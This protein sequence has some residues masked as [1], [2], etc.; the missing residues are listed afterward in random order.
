[1]FIEKIERYKG[2]TFCITLSNGRRSAPLYLNKSVVVRH[3]LAEDMELSPDDVR[4][5]RF[6]NECRRARERALYLL[7]ERDYSARS[8]KEKLYKS[9]GEK[10]A[11]AVVDALGAEGIVDDRRYAERLYEELI[12]KFGRYRVKDELYRK[13]I[14]ADIISEVME[15]MEE[16]EDE[17]VKRIKNIVNDKRVDIFDKD[18]LR[19]IQGNLLR[20]GYTYSQISYAID[21]MKREQE[22]EE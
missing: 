11:E 6:E 18:D 14:P 20:R 12:R 16:D 9:Y 17:A 1:M 8:L 13:G 21:T 4:G 22:E 10:V 2:D 3:S 19:R 5:L 15:T 7:D